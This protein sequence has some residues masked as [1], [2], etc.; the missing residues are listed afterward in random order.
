MTRAALLVLAVA[1]AA[2]CIDSAR[3]GS[4]DRDEHTFSSETTMT[5]NFANGE[6][7]ESTFG[8]SG[9]GTITYEVVFTVGTSVAGTVVCPVQDTD[10]KVEVVAPDGS[11]I[12]TFVPD[13]RGVMGNGR[14]GG[15]SDSATSD[16]AGEWLMR[17]SGEGA[18]T[19]EV[20]VTTASR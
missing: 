4:D 12:D 16:A 15:G 19:A 5:H 2:G 7:R 11:T 6:T 3:D 18:L 10:V 14:C 9:P 17:F 1:L 13:A 8:M 20:R